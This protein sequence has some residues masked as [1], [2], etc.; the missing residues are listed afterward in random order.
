MPSK[1]LW[2]L[3]HTSNGL[4]ETS[5]LAIW[6]MINDIN[7]TMFP[8]SP[9]YYEPQW[10]AFDCLKRI[11]SGNIVNNIY[12][13]VRLHRVKFSLS[14]LQITRVCHCT[15]LKVVEK[16]NYCKRNVSEKKYWCHVGNFLKGN[17]IFPFLM[18]LC[19]CKTVFPP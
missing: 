10:K 7:I 15:V 2:I 6:I 1:C 14:R 8:S 9:R 13:C 16:F 18:N 11:H 12:F 17:F 3:L 4:K 5:P 19:A